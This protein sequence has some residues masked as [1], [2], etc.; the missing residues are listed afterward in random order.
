[1]QEFSSCGAE[2]LLIQG[3]RRGSGEGMENEERP[4]F[5]SLFLTG[6]RFKVGGRTEIMLLA[7]SRG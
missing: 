4:Q 5:L 1:M 2:R 6:E 7:G 3:R